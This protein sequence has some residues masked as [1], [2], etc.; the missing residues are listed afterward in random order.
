MIYTQQTG[1]QLKSILG[2]DPKVIVIPPQPTPE[3]NVNPGNNCKGWNWTVPQSGCGGGSV[4][5][6]QPDVIIT[7]AIKAGMIMNPVVDSCNCFDS[8]SPCGILPIIDLLLAAAAFFVGS[9]VGRDSA[10]VKVSGSTVYR[11][12][13][14]SMIGVLLIL[15]VIFLILGILAPIILVLIVA[16]FV[17][18]YQLSRSKIN[19]NKR[20]ND[21]SLQ[22]NNFV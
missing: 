5:S 15:V 13:P 17:I 1:D 22:F 6:P 20:S 2:L 14:T 19:F 16:A 7:P 8:C 21:Y 11:R 10:A 4:P 12:R 9:I 18:G 3:P